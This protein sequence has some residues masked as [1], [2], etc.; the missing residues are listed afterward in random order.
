MDARPNI[1]IQVIPFSARAHI[2][3]QGAFIVA[4]FAD[5]PPVGAPGH[6]R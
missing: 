3:S 1:T 6:G 4:E 2:G 5:T